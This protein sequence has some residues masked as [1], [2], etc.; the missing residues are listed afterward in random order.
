LLDEGHASLV[1]AINSTLHELGWHTE[2]EVSFANYGERGSIDVLAW[3]ASTRTL[4]VVEVK[5]ELGSV[6]G[7]LRPLD[8]K[9]RLATTMAAER[10]GWQPLNVGRLLVLPENSTAR[11]AIRRHSQVFDTALRA[12]NREV[13]N[14]LENPGSSLA[15]ILFLSS[16]QLMG[17]KRNPSA[18]KRVRLTVPR[19]EREQ[20]IA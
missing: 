13:R 4:L 17:V 10:F 2:I 14:W 5:T 7:L 9:V 16:S 12:R 18:V 6:E 15:G 11:R 19:S 8:V 3:H 20:Q 1:G